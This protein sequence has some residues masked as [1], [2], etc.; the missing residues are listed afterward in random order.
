MPRGSEKK[1]KGAE[2][3]RFRFRYETL[4]SLLNKNGGAHQILSDLEADLNHVHHSD[5]RVK[6]PVRRLITESLLMAQELNLLGG[7]RYADL[8]RILFDIRGET[9]RLFRAQ[10][11]NVEGPL[12]FR[13]DSEDEPDPGL[14][15]GKARGVWALRQHFK[16]AV[17]PGFVLTTGAYNVVL[18]QGGLRDRIRILLKDLDVV[19]DREQF[20]YRARTIRQWIKQATIPRD[21]VRAI[22]EHARRIAGA[23]AGI[24]WAVRSSAVSED[25]LHSFAGQ[26]DSELMVKPEDLTAAYLAVLAGR[27]TERAL[28]YRI[29]NAVR[30]V[31]TPMAVLFMPMVDAVAS[32]VVYTSNPADPDGGTLVINAVRGLAD[33]MVRGE[34]AADTFIVSRRDRREVLKRI[35][36]GSGAGKETGV[37]A[38][39]GRKIPEIAELSIRA[40]GEFG[41]ELDIEWA[42][43]GKSVIHLLQAR[44]L[45]VGYAREGADARPS[46]DHRDDVPVVEGG[47]TVF[48]GRA[49]GPVRFVSGPDDLAGLPEGAVVVT[50]QPSMELAS[51]LPDIAALVVMEG[52]PAG[53]LATLVR[54]SSV[55]CLFRIGPSARIL[56]GRHIVSVHATERKIYS[57][58]RWP[59]I[60]ERVLD[61]IASARRHEKSGPL[62]DLIFK[63]NLL[64]PDARSFKAKSCRSVHDALRFIHEMSV[65]AMFGFGDEQ[66]RGWRKKSRKLDSPLPIKIQVIELDR[67]ESTRKKTLA[68]EDV[69]SLPFAALWKGIADR[70]MAW[71]DRW[72]RE[73]MGMPPEFK[74]TVLGGHR[75]PRRASDVNYA[76]VASDYMNVNAR[77]AYHYAMIDAM[78]GPGAW[79]NYVHFRFRGGGAGEEKRILRA[80]FLESVLRQSGFGVDRSGDLVTAWMRRY[81]Q[82]DSEEALETIGRLMVCARQLDVVLRSDTDVKRYAEFFLQGKYGK[83]S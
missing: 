13:M 45:N 50:E 18:D 2:D 8:Y 61:R 54:E 71:P 69:A 79:K 83:F 10:G 30:E 78:V 37:E 58:V 49:E 29:L 7:K 42:M 25:G 81:P 26:F 43:D 5:E 17:P 46:R 14:I 31:D 66:N 72:G 22:G 74:E 77:F 15:G 65:R 75:G 51:I 35:P 63:L 52:N 82:P 36:A 47:M 3:D 64:D 27:F 16:D 70:R 33:R 59:G 55:P 24:T 76:V 21:I 60:R 56:L 44:R 9:D 40:A 80:R 23:R 32:G 1:G 11:K 68:P 12:V 57:G 62:Y 4:R 67:T 28:K 39:L 48:P 6:R 73:M 38:L 34:E 41:H 19:T 20:A 53:H